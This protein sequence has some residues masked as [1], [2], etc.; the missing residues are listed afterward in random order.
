[1]SKEQGKRE[2]EA[3]EQLLATQPRKLINGIP[4]F[5][6]QKPEGNF[7]TRIFQTWRGAKAFLYD[8]LNDYPNMNEEVG[9]YKILPAVIMV[10]EAPCELGKKRE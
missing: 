8:V 2:D 3:L 6:I 1:M 7:F 4:A 5:I 9:D 10:Y